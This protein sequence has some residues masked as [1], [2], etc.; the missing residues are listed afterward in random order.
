MNT[1]D[2]LEA[3]LLRKL[4][5]MEDARAKAG[6]VPSTVLMKDYYESVM[7]DMKERLSV[8]FAHGIVEMGHTLNDM[9]LHLNPENALE[10]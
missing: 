4:H 7:D 3:Y 9:Y 5:R 2:Y 10:E 6:K 8:L 1:H